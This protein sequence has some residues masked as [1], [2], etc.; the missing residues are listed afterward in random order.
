MDTKMRLNLSSS[1]WHFEDPSGSGV[2][3]GH[4]NGNFNSPGAP[5]DVT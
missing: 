4:G 3:T 1:S 2:V 5:Y